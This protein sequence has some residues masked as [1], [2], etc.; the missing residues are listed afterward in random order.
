VYGEAINHLTLKQF[1]IL[2][3]V[4]DI[5]CRKSFIFST[6]LA[7]LKT[8]Y[9]YRLFWF[10]RMQTSKLVTNFLISVNSQKSNQLVRPNSSPSLTKM[11]PPSLLMQLTNILAN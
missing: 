11:S 9:Y 3:K 6:S 7:S 2:I 10:T 1:L 8:S 4:C 5:S